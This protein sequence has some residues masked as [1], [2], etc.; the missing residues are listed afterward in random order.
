M[1]KL[2]MKIFSQLLANCRKSNRQIGKELGVSGGTVMARTKKMMDQGVIEKFAIIIRPAVFGYNLVYVA[3]KDID[4]GEIFDRA[5][6]VGE[7][8]YVVPCVG[9]VTLCSI[10]I[11]DNVDEK[12]KLLHELIKNVKILSVLRAEEL[13]F[14]QNFTKTD[15]EIVDEIIRDSRQRKEQIAK[16]TKLSTKTVARCIEKL[17][18]NDGVQ[19]TLVCNPVKMDEFIPHAIM[20]WIHDQTEETIKYFNNTFSES[21][22]QTPLITKDQIMLYMYTDSIFKIDEMMQKIKKNE[23]IKAIDLFIPKKISF[24]NKWLEDVV[25]DCKKASKLHL[26]YHRN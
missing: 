24:S 2:D 21:Y 10:I 1:D 19:F 26:T 14:E 4:A 15:I 5:K 25:T 3:I 18:A 11:K 20:V 23:N 16:T 13:E 12:I 6:F 17:H 22:L 8:D 7:L 9:G